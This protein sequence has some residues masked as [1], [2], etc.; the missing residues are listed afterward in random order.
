MLKNLSVELAVEMKTQPGSRRSDHEFG[1]SN[2]RFDLLVLYN[3]QTQEAVQINLLTSQAA[4]QER[5]RTA[6]DD[7][8][9]K[10]GCVIVEFK[11]GEVKEKWQRQV[12]DYA[13]Q[14]EERLQKE[15]RLEGKSGRV[16]GM[17][18]ICFEN[19][20]TNDKN[21]R[22]VDTRF[23]IGSLPQSVDDSASTRVPSCMSQ[24]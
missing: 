6:A 23:W 17:I 16:D 14:V 10:L 13:V 18:L 2:D 22:D 11:V 3:K 9:E 4:L 1:L 5:L 12:K 19:P 24:A 15:Y 8:E 7:G 21:A 20:P